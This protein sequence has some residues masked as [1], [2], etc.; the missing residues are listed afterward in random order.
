MAICPMG[1]VSGPN[2]SRVEFMRPWDWFWSISSTSISIIPQEAQALPNLG[3]L[4]AVV[5]PE[6][7]T[8][9]NPSSLVRNVIHSTVKSLPELLI[10]IQSVLFYSF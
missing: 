10:K 3:P 7:E 1:L 6:M 8:G 5:K 9:M 4:K 2:S